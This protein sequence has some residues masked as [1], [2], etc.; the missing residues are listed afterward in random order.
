LTDRSVNQEQ[1]RAALLGAA[2]RVFARKGFHGARVGDVASEAGVAH[3][4]VYH[5]F[6]SKDELLE[7]IFRETWAALLA[8]MREVE[9][10]DDAAREQLRK[11]GAIVLRTWTRDPDLVRV[12]VNEVTRGPQLQQEIAEIRQAFQAIER[13]VAAGQRRGE[14]R[15]ELDPR[16]AAVVFYGALEEILTGWLLGELPGA[17]ADVAEAE[18]AVVD[19]VCG[20]LDRARVPA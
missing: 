12:L 1:R 4:L 15:E 10:S 8:A 20:G 17:E 7:T 18:R 6:S 3:G 2:V 11:V 13:I 19:I 16:L 14:L 9:E 5:Y